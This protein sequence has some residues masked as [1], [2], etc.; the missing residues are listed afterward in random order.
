M[1]APYDE[2]P[3]LDLTAILRAE[4]HDAEAAR[5]IDEDICNASDEDGLPIE[6][7]DRTQQLLGSD[8][9]RAGKRAS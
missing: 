5:I 4:G 9:W 3:K 8:S 1:A 2:I 6:L 7:G